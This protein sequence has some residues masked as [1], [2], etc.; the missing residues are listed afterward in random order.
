VPCSSP[1]A[2]GPVLFFYINVDLSMCLVQQTDLKTHTPHL[3]SLNPSQDTYIPTSSTSI[4][5]PPVV[6]QPTSAER[7]GAA[8]GEEDDL[9]ARRLKYVAL[10][11]RS[12]VFFFIAFVFRGCAGSLNAC[13]HLSVG[14]PLIPL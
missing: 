6:R 4:A 7:V 5:R 3:T 2:Y 10:V 1:A 11:P 14:S 13:L 8:L 12:V 9:E